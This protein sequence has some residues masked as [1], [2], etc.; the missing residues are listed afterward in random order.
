[1]FTELRLGYFKSPYASTIMSHVVH[2]VLLL[3]TD[4]RFVLKCYFCYILST[5]STIAWTS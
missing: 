4:F 1:M 3:S 2:A 5:Y